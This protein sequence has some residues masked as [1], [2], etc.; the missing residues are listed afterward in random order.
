MTSPVAMPLLPS[1]PF[2]PMQS[3]I[4]LLDWHR[5]CQGG[6]KQRPAIPTF[7]RMPFTLGIQSIVAIKNGE[8]ALSRNFFKNSA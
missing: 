3:L 1:E 4:R 5:A 2:G 6:E 8:I 7:L